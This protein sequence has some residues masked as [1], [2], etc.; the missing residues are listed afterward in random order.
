MI[1]KPIEQLSTIEIDSKNQYEVTF[2]RLGRLLM[3]NPSNMVY[4]V[5]EGKLYGIISMGD[6]RRA[7]VADRNS[8]DINTSF[9]FLNGCD[10]MRARELFLENDKINALPIVDE[11]HNLIGDY[12]R[13]DDAFS[14]YSFDFLKGNK[15]ADRVWEKYKKVA[16]VWP[17]GQFASKMKRAEAWE[18]L[19]HSIGVEVEIIQKQDIMKSFEDKDLIFFSDEDERRGLG[20]LYK[21][22]L[23][24]DFE[25]ARAKTLG[26]VG[27][28]VG[29]TV[30]ETV[31]EAVGETMAE[32]VIREFMNSG[33]YVISLQVRK[34]ESTYWKKVDQE[35]DSKFNAIGAKKDCKT[36]HREFWKEFYDDAYH[37]DYVSD[38]GT[39]IYP[40]DIENGILKLKDTQGKYYN[41]TDGERLTVGQPEQPNNTIYFFGP[42]FIVG[43]RIEDA[44]TVESRLQEILNEK[45]ISS[46]VVNCGCWSDELMLLLRICSTPFKRGDIAIIYDK[47][48]SF[49]G[50]PTINLTECLERKNIPA[51][52]FWDHP[53]HSNH[54]VFELW[55]EEIYNY[56]P[57]HLLGRKTDEDVCK[58]DVK[59][60]LLA[61]AYF[62]RYFVN[63]KQNDSDIVGAIVMNC[64]PFTYGHRFL[65]E[66]ACKKVDQL[67]IFVVEENK[68][69][70]SF[71]ERFAMVREGTKDM[72]NIMV[73]PSGNLILSQQ[74]FPEYFVKI[75]DEDVSRNAEFD[76]ELFAE[77][78]A[79]RLN[80]KYRFV[81][82]EKTDVVTAEYNKAMKKILPQHGIELVEIARKIGDGGSPISATSVRNLLKAKKFDEVRK[83][84]PQT[85]FDIL[86]KS[87]T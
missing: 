34:S 37:I 19:F 51:R 6:V 33:V 60:Q 43:W 47:G 77:G 56:I 87:W 59:Y 57:K 67:I 11:E 75:A 86:M 21:D 5:K 13:W 26:S 27:E 22:I 36:V 23:D 12:S 74:T 50:I 3:E 62:E 55:A 64:N 7:R 61:S 82:E 32:T 78:I 83:L 45:N 17:S 28:A 73:V 39:Q 14:S 16:I 31:A 25:W 76:I 84:V 53:L 8:V 44:H 58:T 29:E 48:K 4:C 10:Y 40:Q 63:Y 70:F 85:T 38:I 15:Y 9:T 79:P 69:L 35:I 71:K 41:V 68:S 72:K 81:G 1:F 49:A 52:W 46:R 54:K 42:C 24:K 66:E 30:G 80:I 2:D 20:S 18:K 65:I